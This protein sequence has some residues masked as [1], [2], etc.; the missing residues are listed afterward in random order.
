MYT[1][2]K[3]PRTVSAPHLRAA[4]MLLATLATATLG[5]AAS[6]DTGKSMN[7][8]QAGRHEHGTS[9]LNIALD[10]NTLA[11]E[12]S[13]PAANFI[14]FE[15]A[16]RT[17]AQTA[18][19]TSVLA[20]LKQGAPLFVTPAAAGCESTRANVTPP[21]FPAAGAAENDDED[22]HAAGHEQHHE[23]EQHAE[24]AATWDFHCSQP[25]L[26]NTITVKVFTAFPGTEK[27]E[28]S[29]IGPGGQA[30][31]VLTADQA[32]IRVSR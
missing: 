17:A 26:L 28:T 6:A 29:L 21:N 9:T 10:G 27:L 18:R 15:H 12:L 22:D 23:G 11:I 25:K 3:L 14:G 31:Q 32:V 8:R 4:W 7:R 5:A 2:E 20:T 30:G 24:M 1:Q 19:L 16:P 13:G